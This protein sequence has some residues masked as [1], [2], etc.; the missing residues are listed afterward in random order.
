MSTGAEVKL[1]RKA[2]ETLETMV[3]RCTRDCTRESYCGQC[4]LAFEALDSPEG[5][6]HRLPPVGQRFKYSTHS[7]HLK[8]WVENIGT[9]THSYWD[10]IGYM[11]VFA[12]MDDG[13][14]ESFWNDSFVD[15]GTWHDET[16]E[17]I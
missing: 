10:E 9:V 11:V 6:R 3:S 12:K 2:Y 16:I 4:E 13:R 8:E 17:L 5:F 14:D 7:F 1:L 15:P